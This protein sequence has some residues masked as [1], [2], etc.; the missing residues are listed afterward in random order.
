[1]T[2]GRLIALGPGAVTLVDFL[3]LNLQKKVFF[4]QNLGFKNC[5]NVNN[6]GG[7]AVNRAPDGST[8]PS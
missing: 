1:M 4:A 7:S 2:G 6:G 5:K 3:S 8:Y